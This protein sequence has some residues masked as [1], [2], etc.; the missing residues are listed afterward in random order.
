MT[1]CG[2]S[3]GRAQI[4]ARAAELLADRLSPVG[5]QPVQGDAAALGVFCME[6]HMREHGHG[7]VSTAAMLQYVVSVCR[8]KRWQWC[9]R[10]LSG[11]CDGWGDDGWGSNTR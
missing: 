2:N 1:C 11:R 3:A 7:V 8:G 9:T 4:Q 10:A 5:E 6:G